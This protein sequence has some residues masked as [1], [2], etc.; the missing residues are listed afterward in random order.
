MRELLI[1]K[2]LFEQSFHYTKHFLVA[3]K[4]T[5]IWGKLQVLPV[6][7]RLSYKNSRLFITR[8][9]K[10]APMVSRGNNNFLDGDWLVVVP[11]AERGEQD[12]LQY[13]EFNFIVNLLSQDETDGK[14]KT[15]EKLMTALTTRGIPIEFSPCTVCGTI[16]NLTFVGEDVVCKSCLAKRED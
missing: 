12:N 10:Q 16:E 3:H 14:Y 15:M 2:K 11:T 6:L 4:E 5:S 13:H 1:N 9:S 8:E 7:Y